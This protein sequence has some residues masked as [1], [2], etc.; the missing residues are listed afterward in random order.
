MKRYDQRAARDVLYGSA[1]TNG[2]FQA[3]PRAVTP[4]KTS[5]FV[6]LASVCVVV[7]AL[8]FAQDVLIPLAL[9]ILLTFLFTPIVARLERW[10]V[11]RPMAVVL[12]VVIA[13]GGFAA[14]GYV[15]GRQI[16]ELA[17]SIDTYKEN[18]I[19]KV[20]KLKPNRGD[21]VVE[22]LADAA[23][24]V[25]K[26]LEG[27][28]TTQSATATPAAATKAATQP[29]ELVAEELATRAGTP[30]TITESS[31]GAVPNPATQPTRENPLPVAVVEPTPSPM[32]TL[33]RYLGLVLGP[34]G[35]AGIVIFFVIFMLLQREDLRNRLIRLVGYGQLTVTT[36]A[37]DDAAS[38]IS[39]Y[40]VAQ[41][42]VNGTY[43]MAIS[44]GLWL[45][46]N[47]VGHSD[48]PFPNVILWGLL[49][50]FLRFIPYIGPWIG[51]AFPLI[52]SLAVYR[53]F[54]V[55]V[56]TTCMFVVIELLSNNIMEPLLYGSSTGMSAVAILVSAVFW[57]WLWGP[58]G[59]LLA[60][61][62]T[63]CLV[64]LGKYVP[65]LQF[66]DIMLGDEP[67]LAPHERLYQRWLALD[68]EEATDL[69]HEF[70]AERSLEDVYDTILIPAL[71]LAEQDRH[72]N[73]LDDPRWKMIRRSLREMVDE[74]GDDYRL[75][76]AQSGASTATVPGKE[77]ELSDSPADVAHRLPL[78]KDCTVNI[79][80][81]PAHDEA[82]EIVGLMLTQVLEFNNYCATAVSQS[83]LAGEMLEMVQTKNAHAVCVSALP[84]SAVTHSRYLCKR[85]HQKFPEMN[86]VVGLWSWSGDLKKAKERVACEGTVQLVTRITG[87]LEEI[88]QATH[89]V[90]VQQQQETARNGD[91]TP[92]VAKTA[93]PAP[94]PS[95]SPA[96]AK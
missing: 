9:A 76:F 52:I 5:R 37:L 11:P 33:S 67:V 72:R 3:M 83:A 36:Q 79:V 6:L 32:Q 89:A 30:R 62:L 80:I 50:A 49:C 39:R 15:V 95:P 53:S 45:I 74:L 66:L 88:E 26:K 20:E 41:A 13:F 63:V 7:A 1:G 90:V 84:P 58:I 94:A 92:T 70:F 23:S 55:F 25:Q 31:K 18:I 78:Q 96:P 47:F 61:P 19:A 93:S 73:R 21:N 17:R 59:L 8:Y 24:D 16:V 69:V 22:K 43:G 40:L 71:A 2:N 12:V 82:D 91:D 85:L 54:N 77:P 48:P 51:A 35:T 56:A 28:A 81:L 34:L 46:G 75:R 64:V 87:A 65:M 4:N 60:T 27:P 42:I 14:L 86:M 10:R 68:P 29:T 44:I 57:T 38:R